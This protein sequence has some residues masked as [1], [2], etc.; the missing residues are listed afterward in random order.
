[1]LACLL[2]GTEAKCVAIAGQWSDAVQEDLDAMV[3]V[4]EEVMC[5]ITAAESKDDKCTT[6]QIRVQL[7]TCILDLVRIDTEVC[8]ACLDAHKGLG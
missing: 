3:T 1:M 7:A 2:M 5:L 8:L 4:L 6:W